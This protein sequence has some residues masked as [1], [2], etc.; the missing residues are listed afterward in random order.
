MPQ[1]DEIHFAS[2]IDQFDDKQDR[3]LI[4]KIIMEEEPQEDPEKA[5]TDCLYALK[6]FPLKEKVKDARIRIRDME[7]KSEDADEAIIEL[8]KLRQELREI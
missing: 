6:S 7:V 4:S 1:Y 8:A 5:V 2:I 3:E